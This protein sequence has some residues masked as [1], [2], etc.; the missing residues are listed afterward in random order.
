MAMKITSQERANHIRLKHISVIFA[1]DLA[2]KNNRCN[3]NE[4]IK[5]SLRETREKCQE[6]LKELE[7][8]I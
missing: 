1:I 4:N 6:A 2:L 7:E 3:W 8:V 5:T